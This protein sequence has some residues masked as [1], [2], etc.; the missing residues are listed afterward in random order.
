MFSLKRLRSP[1]PEDEQRGENRIFKTTVRERGATPSSDTNTDM[2]EVRD[3]NPNSTDQLLREILN[4]VSGL[5]NLY[6]KVDIISEKVVNIERKVEALD[7]RIIDLEQGFEFIETEV[8]DLKRQVEEIKDM[9][10]DVKYANE[11]K[12]NVVDL[13]NRSKRNNVVLHGIPEGVEGD[14]HDCSHFVKEFFDTHMNVSNVEVERAHRTPGGRSRQRDATV[15]TARPRPIH[16]KLLRFNDRE[17]IL[18][19]SAALK[20]V[21]IKDKKIGISDDVHPETREEHRKLMIRVKKLREEGKFAFIPNSIPRV[22]KYKEGAK[23]GPGPLKTL[24]V[25]DLQ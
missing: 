3:S 23:D 4:K 14:A 16:V 12:R 11:L 6:K 2:A 24:R 9:K 15:A 7:T 17:K 13:V 1:S 10:A 8:M 20:D 21:R 5:E 18:K 19:R 22:I 25:T